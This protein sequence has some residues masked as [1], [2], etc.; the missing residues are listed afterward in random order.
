MEEDVNAPGT[1]DDASLRTHG[2]LRE[3]D[4]SSGKPIRIMLL[5]VLLHL[6]W[7]HYLTK[8]EIIR[9][10]P[11]YG[12]NPDKAFYRDLTTLTDCNVK[13]L[14]AP[15]AEDLATWCEQQQRLRRLAIVHDSQKGAFKLIQ[16][17]FSLD[18]T[19][20]EARAFVALQE[21]FVPGTPY[22]SAVQMLLQRWEWLL[23]E[24]GKQL[25]TS[26]RKR[27]GR[28][29]VLPLSPVSDYS[30]HV[31]VILQ[32]DAALE[33]G[34]YVSFAYTPLS[35]SWDDPP[36]QHM[37]VEPYELEYR[38]GHWYF[39]AYVQS[40]NRFLDYRVDR[41]HPASLDS[42]S[43]HDRY[44]PRSEE[45]Q[46]VKIRYWVAP[47]MARHGTLSVRLW[48]Q[49]VTLPEGGQGAYVEG[50]TRSIWWATKLLLG[51]G[52]QVKALEPAE[53]VER[54]R[55]KTQAAARLYEMEE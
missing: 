50:Y 20:D 4:P 33:N 1:Q 3:T 41:I 6:S 17:M 40:M 16:S 55:E 45:R 7:P 30:Q 2:K 32:L 23:S 53:L 36:E 11:L 48:E 39:T 8:Q 49:K 14:P 43:E 54:M 35:H 5:A 31:Q 22:A 51:Y 25:I 12:E 26:K 46:G 10:I 27:K 9:L 28:P 34:A 13:D 38:E 15:D 44:Y 42:S 24:Q 37:H 21:S 29:V 47:E 18:I 19:E 52:D